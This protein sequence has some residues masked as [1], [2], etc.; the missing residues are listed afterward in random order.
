[1]SE[2][3]RLLRARYRKLTK[4]ATVNL[5]GVTVRVDHPAVAANAKSFY[6]E[7]YERAE[8]GLLRQTLR[9]GDRVVEI[10]AGV[11]LTAMVSARIVGP[12]NVL[13]FEANPAVIE[14]ARENAALNDMAIEFRNQILVSGPDAPASVP[15]HVNENFISSTAIAGREGASREIEIPAAPLETL[16]AEW[17]PTVLSL[18]IEGFETELLGKL[19]DFGPVRSIVME[20][21]DH[22]VGQAAADALLAH[23]A[24]KGFEPVPG[25]AED[26]TQVFQR[27][28]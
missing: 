3:A 2:F 15:F 24:A 17:R 11:G 10:G 1:M 4:P 12:E 14:A 6:K 27:E 18:D 28:V 9:P 13:A 20:L 25:L 8:I 23:L 5:H 7:T 19:E 22:V 16:I 21:H 26:K